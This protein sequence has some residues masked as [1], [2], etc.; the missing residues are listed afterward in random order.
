MNLL[1]WASLGVASAIYVFMGLIY[2]LDG[3]KGFFK[4]VLIFATW[5]VIAYVDWV[6]G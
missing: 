5:P 1:T 2:V 3:R 6:T 4:S